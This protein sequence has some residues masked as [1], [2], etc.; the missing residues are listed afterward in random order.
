MVSGRIDRTLL[1]ITLTLSVIGVLMVYSSTSVSPE[2]G[3]Q[4]YYYLKKHLLTFFIGLLLMIFF[5]YTDI[6]TIKA[7][8]IPLL[9]FSFFLLLL[10]FTGLGFTAGGA[11]R[12]LRL[13]PTV[14]QPSELA[15]LSMVIF[16]S[17]YMA[18]ERFESDRLRDILIPVF[19]MA[20]FQVVFI[21]QPDFG[22][23]MTFG[24]L[25]FS[26]IYLSGA[27][28]RYILSFGVL[29]I[30]V[31]YYLIKE[32][33]RW[34]RIV[35][36]LDPWRDPAGSGFQLIQSLIAF[37]SGGLT[38]VGL[39]ESKQKLLYL[40]AIHN[41]FIFALVGEEL[42]F[43]GASIVVLLFLWLFLRGMRIAK[44]TVDG[45]S[46]YLASGISLMLAIQA[47]VNFAVSTGLA[48]TKG[49][50]LPFISYGGSSLVVNMTAV[51][52]LLNISKNSQVPS[53]RRVH[54][55]DWLLER[56]KAY[57]RKFK[58]RWQSRGNI[59]L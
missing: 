31:I 19:V 1:L 44:N 49:L 43:I 39:G 58:K 5:T 10:V 53:E 9:F 36:F 13:W 12:W 2:T 50:P 4:S 34:K 30:P 56:K 17:W 47:V 8:A 38:G 37:G 41:D 46:F 29:L 42:G 57:V 54:K 24:I 59:T 51:G 25:T 26:M 3:T 33:Y 14:F 15:K 20:C 55:K 27:R 6:S 22:A 32:P 23:F 18:R 28:L 35:A 21:K 7:M 52:I 45:F 40:P 11:R 16:L 48:P